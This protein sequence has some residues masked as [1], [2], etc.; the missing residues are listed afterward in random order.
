MFHTTAVIF[1]YMNI[2]CKNQFNFL[3]R[4]IGLNNKYFL[5]SNN[6]LKSN[7][8]TFQDSSIEEDNSVIVGNANEVK[9]RMG[10]AALNSGKDISL[11][12]LVAVSKTKPS[13]DIM[14]LYKAG[15]RSF[16]ENY[17]QELLDKAPQL[18]NDI[19]WHFIG[20]LQ[21]GKANKLIREVKGLHV[22]ETV[23]T[24]KLAKK[25]DAA[26]ESADRESLDIYIQVDT[27]GEDTK[28]GIPIPDVVPLIM[29]IIESCKRLKVKGLMTIGAPGD[30][31]CFDR[32]VECRQDVASAM[33]LQPEKLILSM[34]MSSDYCEAIERGAGSVRVGSSIF[35]PRIYE[36]KIIK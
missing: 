25:L 3:I 14:T 11:I 1:S 30:L 5:S 36:E 32:L 23:D 27:S 4:R 28:S 33:Q 21:S 31:S 29:E 34:G 20:H 18:P 17:F 26:C 22:V 35:G 6:L 15:Y 19:E 16:G 8:A 2:G 12:K 10:E 7:M 24:I 9:R 13:S